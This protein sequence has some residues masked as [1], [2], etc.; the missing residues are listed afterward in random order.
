V[1][2]QRLPNEKALQKH[3][4][5]D[6]RKNYLVRITQFIVNLIRRFQQEFCPAIT[7]QQ[8]YFLAYTIKHCISIFPTGYQAAR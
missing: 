3:E 7:I 6:W 4:N 5:L 2:Q 1:Q 8:I